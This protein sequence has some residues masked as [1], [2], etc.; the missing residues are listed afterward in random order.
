MKN[1]LIHKGGN[2]ARQPKGCIERKFDPRQ[3]VGSAE[4][5]LCLGQVP[6]VGPLEQED[7]LAVVS[8]HKQADAALA[9]VVA[10]DFKDKLG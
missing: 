7:I 3:V 9:S 10:D 6:R 8:Q 5:G 1:M 2:V 4:H